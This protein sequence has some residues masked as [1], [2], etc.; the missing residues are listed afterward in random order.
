L[1][2]TLLALLVHIAAMYLPTAQNVL[3]IEP[4]SMPTWIVLIGCS[5]SVFV[6][7]ELHKLGWAWRNL[8]QA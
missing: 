5:M 4:V 3:M 1:T 8:R 6:A 2:A 7:V